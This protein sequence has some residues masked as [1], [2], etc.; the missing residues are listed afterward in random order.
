M[1]NEKKVFLDVA[2][3][4]RLVLDLPSDAQLASSLGLKQSAWSTRKTR[5]NLPKEAIDALIERE[6]LNPE[7]IYYGI[8][9]VHVPADDAAWGKTF[10]ALLSRA[11][12]SEEGWLI[13]DGYQKTDLKAIAAGKAPSSWLEAE[14]PKAAASGKKQLPLEHVWMFVRD[15]RKVCKIDLNAFFCDEPGAALSSDEA[16]LV[17]AYRKAEKVGKGFI[18]HAAGLAANVKKG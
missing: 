14:D 7:F 16:A 2:A 15:L 3:R 12:K 11:L 18:L 4:L 6:Q 9:S 1:N 13:R 8:G 5:N 10:Q 17:E